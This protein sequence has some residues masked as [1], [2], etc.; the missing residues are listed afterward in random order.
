[1]TDEKRPT[2]PRPSGLVGSRTYSFKLPPSL[3]ARLDKSAVAEGRSRNSYVRH[4]LGEI[5][6]AE[7]VAKRK[8]RAAG[9]A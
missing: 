6:Q 4:K 2:P 7:M 9:R 8:I 3:V 5:L 1:M